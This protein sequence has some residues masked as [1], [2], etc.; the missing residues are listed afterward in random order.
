V[1]R[2]YKLDQRTLQA[3]VRTKAPAEGAA[4]PPKGLACPC[5]AAVEASA[6]AC[7]GCRQSFTEPIA[8]KSAPGDAASA[9]H[10]REHLQQLGIPFEGTDFAAFSLVRP[11]DAKEWLTARGV[12]T[13]AGFTLLEGEA[14][15]HRVRLLER[16]ASWPREYP[17]GSQANT[18]ASWAHAIL[19]SAGAE[20]RA[21]L[22]KLGRAH[23]AELMELSRDLPRPDLGWPAAAHLAGVELASLT[24][25]EARVA[26][27]LP[28]LIAS[29]EE[30]KRLGLRGSEHHLAIHA[31]ARI[32]P[33]LLTA[34]E[35][36]EYLAALEGE[37][38]RLESEVG[39]WLDAV[40][41]VE[42]LPL[43]RALHGALQEGTRAAAQAKTPGF[44]MLA[45]GVLDW[46]VEPSA[47]PSLAPLGEAELR[48]ALQELSKAGFPPALSKRIKAA[49]QAAPPYGLKPLPAW[50]IPPAVR[51]KPTLECP[52]CRAS[53]KPKAV[54]DVPLLGPRLGPRTIQLYECFS[55]VHQEPTL[56]HVHITIGPPGTGKPPSPES[57]LDYPE[58]A[59][60]TREPPAGFVRRRYERWL[61][62]SGLPRR[63][64]L[65]LGGYPH[66]VYPEDP[67]I[68]LSCRH[69]PVLLQFEPFTLDLRLP[70]LR[71]ATSVCLNPECKRPGVAEPVAY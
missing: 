5:G 16:A 66:G 53:L 60:A 4:P 57:F 65:Q 15:G 68:K 62:E 31:L 48:G 47:L 63:A 37:A 59:E 69:P 8:V 45:Q 61:G 41:R 20:A 13:R 71:V 33:D 38:A 58:V 18:L 29:P 49:S 10:A 54:F 3:L 17:V 19:S 42:G 32:A 25:G 28:V 52:R 14:R 34:N 43:A 6:A 44:F 46:A 55:C 64:A 50:L 26:F 51:V 40:R 67:R 21:P 30:R 12:L 27:R 2:D 22:E 11:R 70:R 24:E 7:P 56:E 23:P 9:R 35:R 1:K 39:T 36:R